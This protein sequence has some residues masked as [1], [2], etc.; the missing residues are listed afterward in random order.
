MTGS[1]A[2]P[3]GR[4]EAVAD[5]AR[6]RAWRSWL[7]V[8]AL[9]VLLV[10]GA[11]AVHQIV[12]DPFG[13][14]GARRID[15]YNNLKSSQKVGRLVKTYQYARLR[16]EVVFL[17]DSRVGM[18]LPAQWPGVAPERV[19]NFGLDDL[20]IDEARE[21]VDF[22]VRAHPP[23]VLVLGLDLL[24]FSSRQPRFPVD[25]SRQRQAWAACSTQTRV[26]WQLKETVF[27]F[28]ALRRARTTVEESARRPRS[29]VFS[30]QG[31]RQ[32]YGDKAGANQARYKNYV[33][34]YLTSRYRRYRFREAGLR[35]FEEI[36]ETARRHGIELHVFW[37]P[38]SADMLAVVD[39]TGHW[40]TM[41]RAKRHLA[42]VVPFF[43]FGS[44]N[45]VTRRRNNFYDMSHFL[46]RVGT[47]AVNRMADP[48]VEVPGDFGA[49]L[50]PDNVEQQ[51]E[52][53]RRRLEDY[54]AENR[55][56]IEAMERAVKKR[57]KK[58]EF[59]AEIGP[60]LQF[61][62]NKTP[63]G[64]GRKKGRARKPE[65]AGARAP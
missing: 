60:L 57:P 25:Y 53:G 52:E 14:W 11:I 4:E 38:K 36:V 39:L 7:A 10:G 27:S 3:A 23:R 8:H 44:V 45:S 49:W 40:G 1:E 6:R 18:G 32:E 55:A 65:P 26:A 59:V 22:M 43:D 15:G 61:Q 56:L 42:G 24:I 33:W 58:K 20:Q 64:T 35:D 19:Y 48:Q 47:L 16:P 62:A 2:P 17:G 34:N 29:R 5:R 31:Y 46:G 54:Q 13:V 30:P 28:D 12:I 41:D 37:V 9:S 51:L 63:K 21:T 50:T